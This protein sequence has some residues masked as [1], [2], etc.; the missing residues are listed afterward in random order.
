MSYVQ[1]WEAVKKESP[2]LF[3]VITLFAAGVLLIPWLWGLLWVVPEEVIE[4][5]AKYLD[6]FALIGMISLI[7]WI[8]LARLKKV[9]KREAKKSSA[10]EKEFRMGLLRKLRTIEAQFQPNGFSSR[11]ECLAWVAKVGPLL[12][13]NDNNYTSYQQNSWYLT[14]NMSGNALGGALRDIHQQVL[15]AIEELSHE[16]QD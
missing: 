3:M 2:C 10:S 9:K 12:E 1:I 11:E 7:V 4:F 6:Y 15:L 14:Q 5:R 16:F 13:Y 8:Y